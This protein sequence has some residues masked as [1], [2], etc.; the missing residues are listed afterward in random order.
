MSGLAVFAATFLASAV[1]GV[2]A[3]AIV[4]GVGTTRGWRSALLGVAAGAA[5]LAVV[6]AVLGTALARVP[7]GPL[8]LVVGALLLVF[9]LQWFRKGV[10]RVAA[11]GLEVDAFDTEADERP[12]PASGVDWTAFVVAFKGVLLEGLE[13][14]FIVVSVGASSGDYALAVIGGSAAVVA[15]AAIGVAAG[16][17]VGRVPRSFLI[18]AVGVMLASFGTFW[19]EEGL[20]VSWPGGDVAIAALV[21]LYAIVALLFVALVRRGVLGLTP[22]QKRRR[23]AA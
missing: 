13:V 22:D 17:L 11:R 7:I 16:G 19:A 4:F 3:V 6:V 5:V 15:V 21:V 10:R 9:G 14:A 12:V 18:L 20:G 2:E 1:E 23:V 8:R